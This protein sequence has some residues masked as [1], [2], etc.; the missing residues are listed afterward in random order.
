MGFELFS[1]KGE[2]GRFSFPTV[3]ILASGGL[4]LNDVAHR[5]INEP[6]YVQLYYD[7][8]SARIGI[9]TTDAEDANG[10]PVR[11]SGESSMLIS[12]R[13]FCLYYG[14]STDVTARYRAEVIDDMMVADL[15]TPVWTRRSRKKGRDGGNSGKAGEEE[16]SR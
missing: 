3:T 7:R 12:A 2:K 10:F 14:I 1:H 9:K 11:R 5:A 4:G 8:E 6:E 13:S 15:G 16:E